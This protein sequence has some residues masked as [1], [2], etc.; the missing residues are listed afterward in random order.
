MGAD[1]ALLPVAGE[2]M[3][4][5]VAAA[6]T[7]SGATEVF[8]VGGDQAALS[9]LGLA[10]VADDHPSE[11]PFG[12]VLT[13]LRKA[14][15]ELVVV[16]ACDLLEPSPD[17]IDALIGAHLRGPGP[18]SVVTVPV[19]AGREQWLHAA[20][21]RDV[22]SELARIFA[23]GTRSVEAAVR[24]LA[25]RRVDIGHDRAFGDADRPADLPPGAQ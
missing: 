12:G 19:A 5:R 11:G 3:A 23:T 6:L 9:R 4:A 16:L 25:W 24:A 17:A 10:A 8:C 14:R 15:E 2:P 18:G 22:R 1:K 13:A 20:W 21:S 7:A